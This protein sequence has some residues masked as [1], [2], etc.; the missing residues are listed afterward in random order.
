MSVESEIIV[1]RKCGIVRCGISSRCAPS[2]PELAAEFGLAEDPAMYMEINADS[3]RRLATLILNRDMAY[4]NEIIPTERAAALAD[5]FLAQF[6]TD[7]VHF[8]TNTT[9]SGTSEPERPWS[10]A[11]WNPV[12]AAT[13]DSG[14]LV[15]SPRCCGC[16]WIEDED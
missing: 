11:N 16:F 14:V 12:T 1:A 5:R 4:S 10:G 8:Y 13:F 9:L 3:A 2:V 7:S 15:T 6:G